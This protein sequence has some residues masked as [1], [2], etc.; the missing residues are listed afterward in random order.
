ML[1]SGLSC[2]FC[3][4]H[5]GP[6]TRSSGVNSASKLAASSLTWAEPFSLASSFLP[7][8]PDDEASLLIRLYKG[9]AAVYEEGNNFVH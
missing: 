2:I 8:R 6:A 5:V 4:P 7:Q 9:Q 1:Y 3:F